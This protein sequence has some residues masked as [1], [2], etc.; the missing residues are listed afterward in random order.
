MKEPKFWTPRRTDEMR[1]LH[2]TSLTY[3]EI[4]VRLGTTKNAISGKV[5]R[6]RLNVRKPSTTA[7]ATMVQR[8]DALDLFPKQ[9]CCV[10][11]LGH[12][13]TDGFRFCGESVADPGEPYCAEHRGR[14]WTKNN[15]DS[16]SNKFSFALLPGKAVAA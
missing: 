15:R 16:P 11:P 6:L 1:R 8:L 7:S 2:S 5:Y 12:P 10:F 14:C 13:G 3:A 9:S 4:G